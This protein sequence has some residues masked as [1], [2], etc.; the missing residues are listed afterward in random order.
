LVDV[1]NSKA[2]VV[3]ANPQLAGQPIYAVN[4]P[5]IALNDRN[6]IETAGERVKYDRQSQDHK[7]QQ[8]LVFH[9]AYLIV[10]AMV[11]I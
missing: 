11:F 5:D 7:P 8:Y 10:A 3:G 9:S 4:S 1:V 2:L 6:H